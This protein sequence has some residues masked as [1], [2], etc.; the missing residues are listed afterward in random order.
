MA[1]GTVEWVG[2]EVGMGART[3]EGTV[4]TVA[5][6]TEGVMVQD[7]VAQ[8]W[9]WVQVWVPEQEWQEQG[10][11]L[12]RHTVVQACMVGQ[13]MVAGYTDNTFEE[14]FVPLTFG[15]GY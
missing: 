12:V 10:W 1:A 6:D 11:E 13:G 2:T 9:E 14:N 8:G 15:I 4:A 3:E 5:E 7:W